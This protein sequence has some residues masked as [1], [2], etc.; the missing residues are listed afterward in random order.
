MYRKK[1][2]LRV[3]LTVIL[4]F[5]F[6]YARFKTYTEVE[7][8]IMNSHLTYLPQIDILPCSRHPSVFRFLPS[9][10]L[11]PCYCFTLVF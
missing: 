2:E 7:N 9:L 4:F 1:I 3:K 6:Y 8:D 5:S 11:S 10:F